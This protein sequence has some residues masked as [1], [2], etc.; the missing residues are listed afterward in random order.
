MTSKLYIVKHDETG[1]FWISDDPDLATHGEIELTDD[2]HAS[3]MHAASE[4]EGWQMFI[5]GV[6]RKNRDE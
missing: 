5:A 4:Y 1:E 3:Y 2:E 6:I